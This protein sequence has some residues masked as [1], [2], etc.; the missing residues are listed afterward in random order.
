MTAESG[1]GV[2]GGICAC[3]I[4]GSSRCPQTNVPDFAFDLEMSGPRTPETGGQKPISILADIRIMSHL[5][6]IPQ[7]SSASLFA[8]IYSFFFFFSVYL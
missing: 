4:G 2:G 6:Y 3:I 1:L 8:Q 5:E 7:L